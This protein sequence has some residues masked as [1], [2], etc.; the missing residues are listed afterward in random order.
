MEALLK[1]VF[2]I[3]GYLKTHLRLAIAQKYLVDISTPR[4]RDQ[5]RLAGLQEGKTD[6][7]DALSF[8][9]YPPP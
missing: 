4:S 6:N 3:W 1:T 5:K 7:N 8:L 2:I 9:G